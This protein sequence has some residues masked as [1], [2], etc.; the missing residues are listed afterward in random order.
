MRTRRVERAAVEAREDR[1]GDVGDR[2][3][4]RRRRG[5]LEAAGAV[6]ADRVDHAGERGTDQR[7]GVDARVES[8]HDAGHALGQTRQRRPGSMSAGVQRTEYEP[9]ESRAL[10]LT[11]LALPRATE[12]SSRAR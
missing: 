2:A 1:F 6:A 11:A 3:H 12:P 10:P 7:A 8:A 9:L 5:K 4:A